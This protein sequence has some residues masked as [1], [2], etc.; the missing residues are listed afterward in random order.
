MS[1]ENPILNN[2]SEEP[3]FFNR[4]E[5]RNDV[6]FA[7]DFLVI[8]GE[9]EQ[10]DL[11]NMLLAKLSPPPAFGLWRKEPVDAIAFQQSLRK[12]WDHE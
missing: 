9:T 8:A 3:L 10:A 6:R 4:A 11:R 5:Y 7:A 12:E 1:E 2:P